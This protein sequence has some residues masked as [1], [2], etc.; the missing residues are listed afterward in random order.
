MIALRKS[1]YPFD[2]TNSVL[3]VAEGDETRVRV[4]S[5]AISPKD[6]HEGLAIFSGL[7]AIGFFI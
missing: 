4:S 6:K 1:I 5:I 7:K 3:G 2:Q